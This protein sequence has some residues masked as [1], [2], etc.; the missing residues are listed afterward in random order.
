MDKIV[1][2]CGLP[3]PSCG[4][5]TRGYSSVYHNLWI[6]VDEM[7]IKKVALTWENTYLSLFHRPITVKELLFTNTYIGGAQ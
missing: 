4:R 6:T 1:D 7:W 5:T 3:T 2:N